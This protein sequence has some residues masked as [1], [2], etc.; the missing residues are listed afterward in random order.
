MLSGG[1]HQEPAPSVVLQATP[2]R[3]PLSR[4]EWTVISGFLG[5][6][7]RESEIARLV[8]DDVSKIQMAARLSISPCTVNA[9]LARLLLKL[10]IHSRYQ[11]ALRVFSA[12]LSSCARR[13]TD[14]E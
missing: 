2:T 8:L 10:E 6:T 14:F 1:T 4:E 13:T 11:L 12:Y 9:H 3:V 5:L 7:T